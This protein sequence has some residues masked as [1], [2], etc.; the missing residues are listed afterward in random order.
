M[1][2]GR[3]STARRRRSG[4][5]RPIRH[6]PFAISHQPLAIAGQRLCLVLTAALLVFACHP[7]PARPAHPALPA[8]PAI[9]A[10]V[11]DID[12][13]LAAPALAHGYW[14]VLVKSLKTDET[15][16]SVNARRLMMPASNMKIV[17]LAAAADRLGWNYTYETKVFAAGR[18]DA[19][20]LQGDLIV[21]GCGDPTSGEAPA[22]LGGWAEQLKARGIRL[23]AGRIIGDDNAFDDD[24]LG[25]GW[26]WD[27]LPDDYAAGVS[28]LQFNENAV[29]VTVS[30]GP[31]A[32][33]WAGVS[34]SPAGSGL[35][36]ESALTTSA[37]GT[38]ASIE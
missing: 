5:S 18:I 9:P 8:P 15:L 29:R 38:V 28:A 19:G 30:P 7:V 26:S 36:V 35:V 37:A 16:Y 3:W 32:G 14:G 21:V 17:T 34:V 22:T 27:D 31:A 24:G 11:R 33:D 4:A 6:L 23:I 1:A 12:A 13:L 2:Y 20:V 25:F 10:L